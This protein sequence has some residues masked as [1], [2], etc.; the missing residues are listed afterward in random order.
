MC[1]ELCMHVYFSLTIVRLQLNNIGL[2]L[3]WCM[4]FF[5][6]ISFLHLYSCFQSSCEVFLKFLPK[7]KKKLTASNIGKGEEKKTNILVWNV[8]VFLVYQEIGEAG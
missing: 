3:P 7:R 6:P 8:T 1:L 5:P 4:F 2:S